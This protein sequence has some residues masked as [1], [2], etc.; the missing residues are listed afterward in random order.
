MA[1]KALLLRK[2]IDEKNK[3]LELLRQKDAEFDSREADL[4]KSIEEVADDTPE[5]DRN[6]L[7]ELVSAFD[8]DKTAHEDA[9]KS[10]KDEIA[11]LENDLAAEEAAQSTEPPKAPAENERKDEKKMSIPESRA[12]LFGATAQERT[13]FFEREDV[14]NF[15]TEVRSCIREKRALTN[16]G[17]TIPTVFLGILRENIINYSKLYRHV[18]VR[19]LNGDGRMVIMGTIPEAVWTD[20][21]ANLNELDL[22][23]N[24]VEINCWKVGGF[25]AV[26]NANLEDSDIDLAAEIMT[27]LGQAIGKALDKAILYGT[28]TRM[29]LGIVTRLAQTSE[30]AG[31]PAT[32]RPWADLHTSNIKTTAATGEAL[33]A[34]LVLNFGNAKG[35][36]S[37]GAI[38]HVMNEKT[39]TYLM[40]QAMS[41]NA[42]GAIV[43]GMGGTMPIIG[44]IIEVLEDVPDYNII[45]GYYDL[46]LLGER[47]GERFATSE[48]YKFLAD[49]TIFK[50]TARYD[51]LPVIAEGFVVQAVNNQSASTSASFAPDD[52]NSVQSLMLNTQTASIVGTGTFQLVAFTAPGSGTV[53]W[54]SATTSKA[55]V[56]SSGLVT[57][58]TAG[59]S[60]I[61][62]TCNGLSA[63]CTVTVT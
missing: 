57:G 8:A 55:T 3:A 41:I 34:D 62:A 36:Y 4:A 52:A 32:A 48:H 12:K 24:D 49:Q 7:D 19:T 33:F 21:C 50:A 11:G 25:F 28:G 54:V 53:S 31:Y 2:K 42:A 40:A 20:C 37:R 30:P 43:T 45:S 6:A 9:K 47:A 59:S 13:A 56:S 51:G 44:G 60:V 14:K 63:S 16:V 18:N 38:V 27:A 22:G 23:F 15:L 17:L 26:C 5:E 61:T 1:L 46:Y 29:P 35:K 39:Y 10:L 58:V